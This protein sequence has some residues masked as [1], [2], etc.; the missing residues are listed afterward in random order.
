[1]QTTITETEAHSLLRSIK[2][3]QLD[4]EP[5]A[6]H[7]LEHY[8]LAGEWHQLGGEREQ[9]YRLVTAAGEKFVVKI[10]SLEE[11][12]E[13]LIFQAKALEHIEQ[14]DPALQVPRVRRTI[15]GDLLSSISAGE[16]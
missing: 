11:D 8:G 1:M 13:S 7:V 9:N 3:P 6:D 15:A 2:A 5:V 14:V 16:G 12:E 4:L 10:A